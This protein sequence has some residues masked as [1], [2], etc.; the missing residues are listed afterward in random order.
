MYV[1]L[2]IRLSVRMKQY[3]SLQMAYCGSLY[4][5][6]LLKSVDKKKMVTIEQ[7]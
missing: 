4:R 5:G 2:S 6:I 3:G 1:C 7:K